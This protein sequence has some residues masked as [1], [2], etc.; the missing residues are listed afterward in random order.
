LLPLRRRRCFHISGF[1]VVSSAAIPRP[2][3][4]GAYKPKNVLHSTATIQNAG[5]WITIVQSNDTGE[6]LMGESLTSYRPSQVPRA[7]HL[8]NPIRP[9]TKTG[10][11]SP[12][13]FWN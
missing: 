5:C 13:F 11:P 2:R 1:H 12:R 9:P 7:C 3:E 4:S 10:G 8:K 6:P